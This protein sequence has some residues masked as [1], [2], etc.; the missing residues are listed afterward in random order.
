M[1]QLS[2]WALALFASAVGTSAPAADKYWV[3]FGTYTGGKSEGI[4]RSEFDPATGAMTPAELAAK[5]TNPSFLAIHPTNKFLYAVGESGGGAGVT[6]FSLDPATGALAKLNDQSAGGNGPC[7]LSVDGTGK[8]LVVANY[9][10]GSCGAL[11]I[12]AD[13]T[14][15]KMT[16]FHQ[17]AG[18]SVNPG[19]QEGP[20]AHS[21][22][23]DA[24]SGFAIVA[25][26]GIDKLLVYKLNPEKA[27]LEG[28]DTNFVATPP[29]SG[30][31]HFAF[32][33][34]GKF[35]YACGE[36]NSTILS[37]T[38]DGAGKLV[39]VNVA[40]TLPGGKPVKGNS[41]AEVQVHPSGNFAFVSN[42]GHNSIA[43]FR[44][45]PK[46]GGVTPIGHLTGGV[47]VPRNFA[48]DPTG[49]WI[50][51][52]NQEGNDAVVFSWDAEKGEGSRIG[53]RIEV[54]KPVCVKFVPV[55]K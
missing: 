26:L 7:H 24:K 35:A 44:I 30:P 37:Y 42:R 52:A 4:Y 17:H 50:V 15:G 28:G 16:S 54:G 31:R 3:F 6:A 25:D 19:N 29:G 48:V 21:A 36:I 46:T 1:R 8:C 9:G 40:S 43:A 14:L 49:K 34:T 39:P 12:K 32:H 38:Y 41:T 5:T 53:T 47:N 55:A 45:D 51:V 27:L 13:G 2:R 22:T 10:S 11:P 33:P 20:H 23:I 18:K